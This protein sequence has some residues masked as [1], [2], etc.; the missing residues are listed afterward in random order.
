MAQYDIHVVYPLYTDEGEPYSKL[1]RIFNVPPGNDLVLPPGCTQIV[2]EDWSNMW[3][4]CP[5]ETDAEKENYL[6]YTQ[7]QIT[8]V[9]D[10][11]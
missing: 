8:I 11:R 3:A 4:A 6:I 9:Q 5:G 10:M 1:L 7:L 2:E